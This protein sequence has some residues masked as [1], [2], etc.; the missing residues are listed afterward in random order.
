MYANKLFQHSPHFSFRSARNAYAVVAYV[1]GTA[2]GTGTA[3]SVQQLTSI[4][5]ATLRSTTHRRCRT[6]LV[7]AEN[8]SCW[9]ALCLPRTARADVSCVCPKQLVLT[10]LVSAENSSRWRL[11]RLPRTARADV[12]RVRREQL[13]L[14]SLSGAMATS[15]RG[16]CTTVPESGLAWTGAF[17]SSALIV[18]WCSQS[19]QPQRINTRAEGGFYKK[20]YH[21]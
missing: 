11:S 17:L 14:D 9:R 7:S 2:K 16:C 12:S 4:G 10:C 1:T 15:D 20:R 21:M 3:E 6:C 13:A 18:S 19:S 8:S 5:K